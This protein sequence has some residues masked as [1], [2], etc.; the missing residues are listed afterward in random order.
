MNSFFW[1][2]EAHQFINAGE[3]LAFLRCWQT[4]IL[5]L[6]LASGYRYNIS[7]DPGRDESPIWQRLP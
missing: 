3:S 2:V 1:G 7:R 4:Q 5:V 6:E